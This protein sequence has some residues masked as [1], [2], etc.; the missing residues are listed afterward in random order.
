MIT[1]ITSSAIKILSEQK[2]I[3][4][5]LDLKDENEYIRPKWTSTHKIN[6]PVY[7]GNEVKDN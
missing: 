3:K 2:G 7:N 4:L 5:M 6:N 1:R